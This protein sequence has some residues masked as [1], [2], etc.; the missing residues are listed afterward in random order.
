[1]E[2]L[3]WLI[4]IV[5]L[6]GPRIETKLW[7]CMRQKSYFGSTE[8]GKPPLNVVNII[9]SVGFLM[10]LTGERDVSTSIHLSAS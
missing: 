10:E 6:R 1:M 2:S 8:V 7:L 5:N 9:N 4:F 3:G